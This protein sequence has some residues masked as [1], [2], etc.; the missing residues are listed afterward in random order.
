[1]TKR[2]AFAAFALA[3]V[4]ACGRREMPQTA[5]S[6]TVAAAATDPQPGVA[7]RDSNC[8]AC[9]LIPMGEEPLVTAN[10]VYGAKIIQRGQSV[11]LSLDSLVGEAPDGRALWQLRGRFPLGTL[12][13]SQTV[14]NECGPNPDS[15]DGRT[16]GVVRS[17]GTAL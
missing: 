3:A 7:T 16:I 17:T 2:G 11:E 8:V 10:Q 5:D 6:T 14:T 15:Q 9:W 1:M 4:A 12:A 13:D